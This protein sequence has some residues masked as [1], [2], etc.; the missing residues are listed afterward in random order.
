MSID[1]HVHA[2]GHRGGKYTEELLIPYLD[3]ARCQG[4]REIGFADHDEYIEGIDEKSIGLLK[5]NF[6]D[7][8]VKLGLE[9][10]Y[11]PG[12]EEEIK[13]LARRFPFD[14]LI[15][16]IHD[17]D[18][19]MFDHP[20]YRFGYSSWDIDALYRKYYGI[21]EKLAL[22]R[23][24]DIVGHLDVIKVFDYR[25][26][27]DPLSFAESALQAISCAGLVVEV[28]TAGLRKPCAEIYPSKELLARCFELNIPVTLGSDAHTA[29]DIGRDFSYACEL[30][31]RIGY[32]R[33]TSFTQ[34]RRCSFLL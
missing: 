5:T 6:P 8:K 15:G 1:Y 33:L 3:R 19:W 13:A 7:I 18:S 10:S 32:R 12:R 29:S 25:P 23:L 26:E 20:D 31:Y 21:L 22:S 9:I 34:R 30:L 4:I 28:N 27:G 14:Y 17:L 11:R 24:F 2:L 16:S